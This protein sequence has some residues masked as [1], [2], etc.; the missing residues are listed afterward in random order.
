MD[1]AHIHLLL[2]YFPVIGTVIGIFVLLVGIA[3]RS[4]DLKRAGLLILLA[5]A[6][7]ALPAYMSGNGAQ[8]AIEKSPGISKA[9]IEAHEGAAMW[10]LW[11]MEFT[12]AFAWLGLWQYRR[13]TRIGRGTLAVVL[14]L[15]AVTFGLM[16]RASTFG[17][18]ITH[19]EIR[20]KGNTAAA[21]PYA[22]E[23]GMFVTDNKFVW[24]ACETLHFIGLSLLFGVSALVDLRMLGFMKRVPFAAL[25]RLLPWAI[26]GFGVNLVTGMLFFIADP[27]QYTQNIAFQWKIILILVAGTN[28]LYFTIFDE[29]WLLESGDDAPPT[30]KFAA[31]SALILVFGVMYFGRMLPFLGNSF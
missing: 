31:A 23:L 28:V 26:L 10:G 24:P 27:G 12:G 19:A 9:L 22:R 30:A 5:M 21:E 20:D 14:L 25:H 29:P 13:N 4:N 8:E 18:E 2:N 6:L 7:L 17:G 15:S 3:G 11:V 1:L 16:A